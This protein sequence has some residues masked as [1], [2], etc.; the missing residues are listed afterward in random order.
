MELDPRAIVEE[1]KK[2][3]A[4]PSYFINNYIKVIHPVR[5]LVKFKLYDFQERLVKD[6]HERRFSILRKFRQA[7]CTTLACAYVLWFCIF[8][9]RKTVAILSKG[10]AEAMEFLERVKIMHDE[11]PAYLKPD[12]VRGGNNK[13]TLKFTNGSVIRSRASGKQ[14]GRSIAGSLLIVDEA[15]F[16]ENIRDIWQASYP[17]LSAGGKAIVLSTVNGIGNWFF[18]IYNGAIKGTNTFTPLDISWEE[19]PEYKRQPGYESLYEEMLRRS[20]PQDI[21]KWEETTKSNISLKQWQQEYSCEFLGTGDT[22]LN[23]EILKQLREN[24]SENFTERYHRKM[25]IWRAPNPGRSYVISVDASLGREFD[26]SAFHVIDLYNGEQVAEFYSNKTPINEF[27]RILQI[28]GDR[29]N[30]AHIIPE[31][32]SIGH[33][34]IDHLINNYGYDNMFN[35][36]KGEA[37]ILLSGKNRDEIL[38]L[39]EEDLRLN[40]IKINSER[41]VMELLTFIIN[42][43]TKK[44]EADDG[45]TDD[46]VMALA[47]ASYAMKG[48]IGTP[49]IERENEVDIPKIM[50]DTRSKY[51]V[52]IAT[53]GDSIEE[54]ISWVL[55]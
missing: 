24:I 28:E 36:E 29:Y 31:R 39:M 20:P 26:N 15:A 41:T 30:N 50:K 45:Q 11:L 54:D 49:G 23:G 14:A 8:N 47:F 42:E 5:G 17:I 9:K 35:D 4:S 1:F 51:K 55:K 21:D 38:A 16:I 19:H 12:I 13:R 48:M 22:Y 27:A 46:L 37:G 34:L 6:F 10:D 52:S 53:F 40:R 44:P 25:R 7:G 18:D 2:C 32:N 3:K 33:I 43:N